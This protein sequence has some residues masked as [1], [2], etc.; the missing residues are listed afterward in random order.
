[1]SYTVGEANGVAVVQTLCGMAFALILSVIFVAIEAY[2]RTPILP[3]GIFRP[4]SLA[5]ANLVALTF[6]AAFTSLLFS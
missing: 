3:L 4:R 1:M 5:S 6:L 2:V